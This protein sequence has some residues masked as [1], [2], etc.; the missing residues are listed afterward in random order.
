MFVLMD[1]E[2]IE[3]RYHH[4]N[5]TQIAAMRVDEQW[6]CQDQFYS[7]IYPRDNSFH[8]WKHMAYIGGTPSD[9]LYAHGIYRV[10]TDLQSWLREDDV[11]CFWYVDS[12][13]IL[14]SIYNLVLKIKVPQRIVVLGDYL[15]PFLAER[16]MKIGNA[17]ALCNEYGLQATGPKHHSENDVVAMQKALGYIQY[18]AS[19]LY[20]E[21]PRDTQ[22]TSNA[23]KAS[24]VPS[25]PDAMRPYQLEVDAGIFHKADCSA[26]P[27]NAV[28]T[29]HPDL[30]YFFRKKLQACPHC[31]KEDVRKGIRER[32]Q[33]IINRTQY[34]FIYAEHSDVFHRRGCPAILSTTDEIK[35]SGYYDTV[36]KTGRR[37]CKLCNP[38][39]GSW[40]NM[41]EKKKAKRVARQAAKASISTTVVPGR[42]MNAREQRAYVRY[43]EARTERFTATKDN[44]KS[45]TEKNDFY[46]LTQP[47]FAF[48]C[49]AGYQTFH[50]RNCQKLHG[51]SN[52]TGFSRYK[53]AIRSGHTP[54]KFCKPTAKLDIECSIPITN[55][56]RKGESISDLETLCTEQG[57]TY[58]IADQYFCFTTAMGK[59]KIDF[60]SNPYIVYH[61]NRVRTPNNEHDY[62]RQPRLFLSLLDTF[63]YI[64]RHD[65]KLMDRTPSR[66]DQ[67]LDKELQVATV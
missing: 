37:P 17:Y 14:K 42:S 5:P 23:D 25:I 7:R 28:L 53:D 12:K 6:N 27:S 47:R 1:I 22:A 30:K 8:N 31:M 66:M 19:L 63:E 58:E 16:K 56:R 40:L 34:Q 52:I 60:S 61:I 45:E 11:I 55:K 38:T 21:P 43:T 44:F 18:P 48:F 39:A 24:E 13:N 62:H 29:G 49:S 50:R 41:A 26:I 9:F 20:G 2:W 33:D 3:N 10:L 64:Q 67:E 57:Y 32:N 59:W 65:R 15:F 51:L 54:C 46:T 36:A 35:G 4:I